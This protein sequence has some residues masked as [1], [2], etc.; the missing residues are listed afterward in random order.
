MKLLPLILIIALLQGCCAASSDSPTS[1]SSTSGSTAA[2]LTHN[3]TLFTLH[4]GHL[5]IFDLTDPA[6]PTLAKSMAATSTETLFIEGEYLFIGG[7]SGV[8]ILDISTPTNPVDVSFYAH[9]RG[10]DPVIVEDDIGYVTLRTRPGCFGDAN[11]LEIV[12]FSDIYTPKEIARYPMTYPYGLAKLDNHLAICEDYAGLV[13]LSITWAEG[14]PTIKEA[15]RYSQI[16][17]FDLIYTGDNLITTAH[18][19]IYQ[20]SVNNEYLSLTSR[21]PIAPQANSI[22]SMGF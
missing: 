21:I 17:C 10:C 16:E 11:R 13:L 9:V 20:F 18:D 22:T 14:V 3:N 2:M 7:N 12:D 6:T 5:K 15:S 1:G 8:Q 19:G 4:H